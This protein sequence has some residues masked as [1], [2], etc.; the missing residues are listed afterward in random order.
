MKTEAFWTGIVR[1]LGCI[2]AVGA[3]LWLVQ[4]FAFSAGYSYWQ[5]FW[6]AFLFVVTVRSANLLD[7]KRDRKADG[8]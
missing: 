7:Y 6:V 2:F 8:A 3:E 1:L 5:C 4:H